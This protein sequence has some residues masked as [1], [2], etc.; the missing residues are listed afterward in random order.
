MTD[1]FLRQSIIKE[2]E[3]AEEIWKEV[4]PEFI[5]EKAE[6]FSN[7]K[8]E[9]L[10][11]KIPGHPIVKDGKP[12]VSNFIALILDI[13]NSTNHLLQAISEKKSKVSQLQRVL[14]ETTAIYTAGV[15]IIEEN[16]GSITEFL[17]DG[18]L[19]LFNTENKEEET[20]YAS[21][22]AAASCIE[23]N[24]Y[25]VNQILKER[26]SLPPLQIGIGLAYSKA[27]VTIVGA[28]N[29]LHAKALGECV[30][31][32]SKLSKGNDEIFIDKALKYIWPKSKGG[33]INF[34]ALTS[35]KDFEAYQITKNK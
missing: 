30:Y 1:D 6:V 28:N 17:G 19:A 2:L 16:N 20:I 8:G 31:R 22:N 14:Y 5:L 7:F 33:S 35:F 23:K 4:G 15:L 24:K 13:R 29:N 27:I 18:F 21:Y 11:S 32:A 9:D 10:P 12:K 3:K 34:S 26:Y 25:I